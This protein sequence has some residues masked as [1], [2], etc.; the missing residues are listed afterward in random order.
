MNILHQMFEMF[1][2]F[3]S[4]SNSLVDNFLFFERK[5]QDIASH[6]ELHGGVGVSKDW[7]LFCLGNFSVEFGA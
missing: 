5:F 2:K 7:F 3:Q 4:K 6:G 1:L